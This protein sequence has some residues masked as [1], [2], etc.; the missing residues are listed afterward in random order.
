[1]IAED[2]AGRLVAFINTRHCPDEDDALADAR[3]RVWLAGITGSEP[4]EREAISALRDLRTLREGI[5]QLAAVN[6]GQRPD[7]RI[8]AAAQ[9]ILATVPLHLQLGD[10][11]RTPGLQAA[12]TDLAGHCVAAIAQDYLALRASGNWLRLKACAGDDCRWAYLDTSRNRS[13]R[14]CDMT[15][16]GNRAKNRSWRARAHTDSAVS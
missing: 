4:D 2:A 15:L 6:N 14:W 13:R 7:G 8:V 10:E 3:G 11:R 16:C 5:R 12:G 9:E 1:M